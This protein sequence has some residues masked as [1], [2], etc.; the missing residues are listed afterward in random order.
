LGR[1]DVSAAAVQTRIGRGTA[2]RGWRICAGTLVLLAVVLAALVLIPG[3]LGYQRYVITSGSMTGTIDRGSLVFDEVV[4]ASSLRRGDIITYTPPPVAGVHEPVTHR[5]YSIT[6][7]R[8]GHTIFRTKGDYNPAPDAWTFTL[9]HPTQG[10]VAFHLPYV[11][12]AFA[13]LA[14]PNLRMLI[15]GIPALL[16][17]LSIIG[18]MWRDAG[19][20]LDRR[21]ALAAGRQLEPRA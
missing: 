13:A 15:I 7:D 2:R 5:I 9:A 17:A 11:G 1:H 4:S 8:F 3:L 16:I 19:E 20:E 21:R 6:H 14:S 18:R 10:R 12:F